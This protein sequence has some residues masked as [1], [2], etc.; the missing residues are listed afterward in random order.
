M[1]KVVSGSDHFVFRYI[2]R[3]GMKVV[4]DVER[5]LLF[6]SRGEEY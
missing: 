6:F 5:L 3:P 2:L 1:A 4:P